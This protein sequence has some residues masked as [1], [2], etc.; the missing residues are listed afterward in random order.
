MIVNTQPQTIHLRTMLNPNN[1]RAAVTEPEQL[2][3]GV[4][5]LE[6]CRR[7]HEGRKQYKY[8]SHT[9]R[10]THHHGHPS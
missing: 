4:D 5:F 9:P 2:D 6:K 8:K 1:K 7:S 3:D 10:R